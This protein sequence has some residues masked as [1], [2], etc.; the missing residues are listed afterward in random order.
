MPQILDPQMV[1]R[2]L[3]GTSN[4]QPD[5]GLFQPPPNMDQMPLMVDPNMIKPEGML[6][7]DY[8]KLPFD[9]PPYAEPGLFGTR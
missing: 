1:A 3:A 4:N 2:L 8:S 5:Q 6:P 7:G 9:I